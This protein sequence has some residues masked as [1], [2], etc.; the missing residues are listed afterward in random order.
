M[1]PKADPNFKIVGVG[2]FQGDGKSDV[3][4]DCLCLNIWTPAKSAAEK[5]PVLVWIYGGGF[6]GGMVLTGRLHT[7][8]EARAEPRQTGNLVG[9]IGV[10]AARG[11]RLYERL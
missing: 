9:E 1:A 4:E 3:S 6:V 2:D 5:L 10:V 7:A 11:V 8:E